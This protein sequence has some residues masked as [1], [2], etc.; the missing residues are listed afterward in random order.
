ML[1]LSETYT[2]EK[3]EAASHEI[4]PHPLF[5]LFLKIILLIL[6]LISVSD[7]ANGRGRGGRIYS[8]EIF[9]V[10]I[11]VVIVLH[12]TA[13]RGIIRMFCLS[14][15]GH[16]VDFFHKLT[17]TSHAELLLHHHCLKTAHSVRGIIAFL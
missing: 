11:V 8:S 7:A 1:L 2:F 12:P 4:E 3:K 9:Q 17:I 13:C 5:F 10:V 14:F 16:F 6:L 15:L